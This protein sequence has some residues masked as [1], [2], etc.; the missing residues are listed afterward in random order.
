MRALA[1]FLLSLWFW[2]PLC[3]AANEG[4]LDEG[5]VNPGFVEK[6]EWF[7]SSFL[8]LREDLSEAV[9]DDKRLLLYFY[10]D[11]CPYCEKLINTNFAQRDIVAKTR[12]HFDVIA[13]NM[14]GDNT[15]TAL[16]GEA[17]SEKHF[18]RDRR[19]Q[20]TPTLLF[21]NEQGEVALRI[22]GYY[23]PHKFMAALDYVSGKAE[24]KMSFRDYLAEQQPVA[25]SGKLHIEKRFLQPPYALTRK[26]EDKPL[27]VLFEQKECA[28]C[29]ELHGEA[30]R[31]P[32]SHELLKRFDVA[33]V[34]IW[35]K[36]K[37]RTPNGAQLEAKV[38]AKQLGIQ[39]APSIV[40]FD[41]SGKEVF[42]TE[43]YLRP[44]HVQSAMEYVASGT[45]KTQ[46]E[47]Q[48]YVQERAD[49]LREQG[50]DVDIWE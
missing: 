29:D 47:F 50:V 10:Q 13:I 48:R 24:K 12:S 27:M 32:V 41:N 5:L 35:S 34:D 26:P 4:A 8:D 39:Y 11:G 31:R 7:K 1:G 46:P 16:D 3:W 21:L 40:F 19:V 22:N 49:H 14:W 23:P 6:P 42:R 43:A 30:L 17:V 44:F 36:D 38:W 9:M 15:V 37:L 28:V 18:S 25:A 20:F 33:V 45:Y 2:A